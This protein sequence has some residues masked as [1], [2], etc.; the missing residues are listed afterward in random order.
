[1]SLQPNFAAKAFAKKA[2]FFMPQPPKALGLAI[3]SHF[4]HGRTFWS[5]FPAHRKDEHILLDF[6]KIDLGIHANSIQ[7]T[8]IASNTD[9]INTNLPAL[10]SHLL[11]QLLIMDS[12]LESSQFQSSFL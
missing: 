5:F 4:T 9:L 7:Y 8:G 1:M 12:I 2:V 10:E 11:H 3:W 6:I